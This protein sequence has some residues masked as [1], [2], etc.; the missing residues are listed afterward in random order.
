MP[1]RLQA[2]TIN[3]QRLPLYK[4]ACYSMHGLAHMRRNSHSNLL[5]SSFTIFMDYVLRIEALQI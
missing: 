4:I 5:Q 2:C 3:E 1:Y